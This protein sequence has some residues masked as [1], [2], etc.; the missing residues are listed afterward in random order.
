MSSTK[1]KGCISPSL[2]SF[3][4]HLELREREKVNERPAARFGR[5]KAYHGV[6]ALEE[7][8]EVALKTAHDC[9]RKVDGTKI[10]RN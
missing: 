6:R 7:L 10:A 9:S 8:R 2:L 1:D 3:I 4:T 5:G